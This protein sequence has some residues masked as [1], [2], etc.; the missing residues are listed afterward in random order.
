[1]SAARSSTRRAPRKARPPE[2]KI[3][4]MEI[5]HRMS[6]IG[7]LVL[8]TDKGEVKITCDHRYT[9]DALVDCFGE[10]SVIGKKIWYRVDE[11]DV[12]A[13]IGSAR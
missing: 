6:S 2:G 5:P 7:M 13:E 11:A 8:E 1:M 10:V 4:G 9:T 3:L 12:L